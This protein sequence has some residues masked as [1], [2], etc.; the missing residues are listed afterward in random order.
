MNFLK[1][2]YAVVPLWQ[3]RF[4]LT[5]LV[6][7]VLYIQNTEQHPANQTADFVFFFILACFAYSWILAAYKKPQ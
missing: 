2:I 5:V 6:T 7:G 3:K 1:N 4:M